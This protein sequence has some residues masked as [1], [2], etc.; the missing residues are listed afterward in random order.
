VNSKV[1]MTTRADQRDETRARILEAAIAAFSE[2]GF[3]AA[4]TRDVARR[5]AV[6]QGLVT[7]HF[8]SKEA[9][10][11]ASADRIFSD[12]ESQ[13]A[14]TRSDGTGSPK[15]RG[16]ESIRVYVRFAASHPELFRFMVDEGRRDEDRMQWLVERHVASLYAGLTAM[17]DAADLGLSNDEVAHL[18]YV[19]AGAGSLMFAVAPECR[20]LTGV[21][22][23]SR[24]AIEAHADL[25][26]RLLLP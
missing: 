6:S 19:I 16:R 7:Y 18:Y 21:D 13:L 2:L 17:F 26:A 20:R 11:R 10:W 3:L 14:A 9:L 8:S 5:A 25:V 22:P 23:S 4:S 12:L 24:T 15:E 1:T